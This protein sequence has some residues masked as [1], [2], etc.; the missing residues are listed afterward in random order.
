MH[1]QT[2]VQELGI[3]AKQIDATLALLQEGAT[4]PFIA[5]YRKEATNGLDEV[6]IASIRDRHA[7]LQELEHRRQYIHQ[8]IDAQGKLTPEL[9]A[10]IHAATTLAQLEDLY[11]QTQAAHPC[12]HRP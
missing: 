11:L 2:I 3:T 1:T 7:Q 9:T 4:V 10:K 6:Q 12:H 5:R 8:S